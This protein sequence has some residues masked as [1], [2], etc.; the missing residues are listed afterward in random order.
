MT[1]CTFSDRTAV[2]GAAGFIAPVDW[3]AVLVT[4]D[5]CNWQLFADHPR[6]EKFVLWA[7]TI[8]GE[9]RWIIVDLHLNKWTHL[10]NDVFGVYILICTDSY[11]SNLIYAL[12]LG[13]SS[14][15]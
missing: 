9:W 13:L 11:Q 4:S 8:A 7:V 3:T 6:E 10:L 5:L 1:K 2:I 14:Q 15:L 12:F